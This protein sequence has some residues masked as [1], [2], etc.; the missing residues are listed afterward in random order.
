STT[1]HPF[2]HLLGFLKRTKWIMPITF[3]ALQEWI[4]WY[5]PWN[6]GQ[7]TKSWIGQMSSSP[8]IPNIWSYSTPTLTCTPTVHATDRGTIGCHKAMALGKTLGLKPSITVKTSGL[9]SSKNTPISV[10]FSPDTF[11]IVA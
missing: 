10:L 5:Y 1:C 3:F 6:L 8:D 4:G 2:R 7:E 9:S 11:C